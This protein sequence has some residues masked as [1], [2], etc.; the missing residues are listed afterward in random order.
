[1]KK[2]TFRQRLDKITSLEEL[3]GF[4]DSCRKGGPGVIE[5]SKDDWAEVARRKIEMG[6]HNGKKAQKR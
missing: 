6:S 3:E 5:L 1:M 2:P 4:A